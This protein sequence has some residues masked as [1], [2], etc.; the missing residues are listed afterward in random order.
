[1][2]NSTLKAVDTGTNT[3]LYSYNVRPLSMGNVTWSNQKDYSL[4]SFSI[5]ASFNASIFGT[6]PKLPSYIHEV[7]FGIVAARVQFTYTSGSLGKCHAIV[8]LLYPKSVMQ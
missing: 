8:N 4:L 2:A 6:T 5:Q 7:Q 1:M 3:D